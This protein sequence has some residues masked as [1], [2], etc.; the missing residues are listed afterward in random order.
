MRGLPSFGLE[1]APQVTPLP[2]GADPIIP[3]FFL[4]RLLSPIYFP[5]VFATLATSPPARETSAQFSNAGADLR[6]PFPY[7]T[8]ERPKHLGP[9]GIFSGTLCPR[10]ACHMAAAGLGRRTDLARG[11]TPYGGR[12][13]E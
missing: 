12:S 5:L 11:G 6:T 13:P 4:I 7:I 1:G 8:Q 10:V 9:R 3:Q 2:R